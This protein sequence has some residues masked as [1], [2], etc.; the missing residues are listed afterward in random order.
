LRSQGRPYLILLTHLTVAIRIISGGQTGV[1]RAALDF[2]IAHGIEH[3]GWCPRGR[4][5]EDGIIPARYQLQETESADPAQRTDHNVRDSDATLLITRDGKLSGGTLFTQ[6][7]AEKYGKW[8]LI[9][10]EQDDLAQSSA[11]LRAFIK[12]HD[13]N[14][15]NVAGPRESQA[16]GL[17]SFV[18]KLL[19][20]VLRDSARSP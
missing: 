17:S 4:A 20:L 11:I 13:V 16:Q 12:E 5:A 14:I 19:S 3:G 6:R 18:Q 2:A 10:C 7:C 8:F 1:D 15:L 9:V